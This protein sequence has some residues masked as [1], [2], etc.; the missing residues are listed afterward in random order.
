MIFKMINHK[1]DEPNQY[2]K[3]KKPRMSIYARDIDQVT[4]N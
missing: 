4:N 2:I 1:V 3:Y